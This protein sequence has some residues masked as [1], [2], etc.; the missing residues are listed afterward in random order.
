[1]SQTND[2][3]QGKVKPWWNG[4]DSGA[5]LQIAAMTIAF[6]VAVTVTF[7]FIL[8]PTYETLYVGLDPAEAGQVVE[9]LKEDKIPYKL[10][11]GGTTVSIP[12]KD[13]YDVRLKMASEGIPRSGTVG[14][15]IFDKTNLG[16]TDFLQKVNYRRALEGE[17]SKSI[18]SIAEVKAARV[19]LVIPEPR[20]FMEDKKEATASIILHLNGARSL[21]ERQVEGIAYLVS[22]S[23]EG[24]RPENVTILDPSGRLLSNKN[25]GDGVGALTS[26]QMEIQRNV[27]SYL[28][29][30]ARSMLDPVIGQGKSVVTISA[31]LNFEQVEKTMENYDPDNLAIRSEE[32]N[33]ETASEQNTKEDGKGKTVSNSTE[34]S[35]TNYE[36]TKTIQHVVSQMGNISKLSVAVVVDGSYKA[37]PGAKE[38]D[39]VPQY[40]PRSQEELDKITS[41]VKGAV[42]YDA[43]RND[44]F[45][46]ANVAFENR[47]EIEEEPGFISTIFTTQKI[48]Y[49]FDLALKIALGVIALM[50]FMK[51][52]KRLSEYWERQR[53]ESQ[54]SMAEREI[55]RKRE[56]II[57][58]VST[59]PQL[60]DHLRVIA[61]EKPTEIAKVIRTMM[62]ES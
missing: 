47:P 1:M 13:I 36:V 31:Q 55:V 27:E 7:T 19:H 61:N 5:R 42:G 57:P 2:I 53:L 6:I 28:E 32:R 22:S 40:A 54:R 46:I 33:T 10:D 24:L 29:S 30:K 15:E 44:V 16:M 60:V 17:L 4:L 26:S 48:D 49:W 45:E 56:E 18:C 52:K 25:Y 9:K 14:Y 50:I 39:A 21:S 8:K 3:L 62:V 11:N 38:K 41:I 35:V 51:L 59:E 34:N 58:K 20:L 37:V 23:V 43:E 12:R